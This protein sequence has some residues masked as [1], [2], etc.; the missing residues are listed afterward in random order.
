MHITFDE[1]EKTM[2]NAS[3][4]F[5]TWDDEYEKVQRVL[6]EICLTVLLFLTATRLLIYCLK[7]GYLRILIKPN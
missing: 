7:Y 5:Q 1:F 6:N 4:V 3:N 2:S